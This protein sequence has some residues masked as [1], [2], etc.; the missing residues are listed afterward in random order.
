MRLKLTRD[1]YVP[2]DASAIIRSKASPA[3]VYLSELTASGARFYA[4]GFYGKADKPA[5][6]YR[7]RTAERRA[8]Y[9]V[10]WMKRIDLTAA[11]RAER[12]ESR[13]A[14]RHTLKLGDILRSSWGYD[15]TNIEFYEIVGLVG[16]AMVLV[17]EIAQESEG[18]GFMC[19][20]CVP[21][22][23]KFLS[24]PTRKRVLPGNCLDM[25]NA[26]FGRA[27]PV[28]MREVAPGVKVT[29]ASYWSSYA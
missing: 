14:F 4:M 10:E 11:A 17:R 25:H 2:K 15:Q 9:V 8:E 20:K 3:V 22:P 23:G 24:E 21:V 28:E 29:G 7:F 12:R 13:K 19:G 27:Y 1:F 16:V 18:T 26:S 5:F 6:N